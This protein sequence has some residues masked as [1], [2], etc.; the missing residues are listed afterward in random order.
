MVSNW[1]PGTQYDY[2]AIV[3]YERECVP[4]ISICYFDVRPFMSR[5]HIQDHPTSSLSGTYSAPSIPTCILNGLTCTKSDWTPDRTPAL[6]GL[7]Q[8]GYGSDREPEEND[9]S[10]E[11]QEQ[12]T[13]Q[14]EIPPDH[15]QKKWYDFDDKRKKELEVKSHDLKGR[16][17][18]CNDLDDRSVVAS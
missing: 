12:K 9:S 6:W 14:V 8:R 10:K 17:I 5:K 7:M 1:E 15:R 11:W 18:N 2:G 16:L 4:V 13:Q 3:E